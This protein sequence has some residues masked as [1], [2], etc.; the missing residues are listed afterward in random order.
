MSIYYTNSPNPLYFT[1]LTTLFFASLPQ[2]TRKF[3]EN[4]SMHSKFH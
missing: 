3:T 4:I 2:N 1:V